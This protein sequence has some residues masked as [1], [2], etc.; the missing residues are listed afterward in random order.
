MVV[1][2][3]YRYR[4]YPSG[5][6]TRQLARE[7][8]CARVVFND[9]I[10]A[11]EQARKDGLPFAKTSE[12]SR[13][14]ITEAKTTP[15]RAWFSEV[16][17]VAL[18]S[19]LQDADQAYKNFFNSLSGKRKGKRVGKPRAK[20]RTARQAVRYTRSAGFRVTETTHGVGFVRLPKMGK[21]RFVLSRPLPSEP[22]SVTVIKE[23]DDTYYVSFVVEVTEPPSVP[24]AGH[25]VAGIDMG[26]TDFATITTSSGHRTKVANPRYFRLAERKLAT[27]QR[28]LAR[29]K[30]GSKNYGKARIKV[31]RAH[32]KVRERRQDF[33][34]KLTLD[35]V[36]D[37]QTIAVETLSITGL[38]RT[39]LAKSVHDASWGM[40]LRLLKERA[41]QYDRMVIEIGQFEPTSQ[42][43][44]VCGVKDGKK[45]LHVRVWTCKE[46]GTVLDRD[47][48]AAVNII[49]AA[50]LAETL[51]GCGENVRRRLA[52]ATIEETAAHRTYSRAA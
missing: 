7:F 21:V 25:D 18:Q 41:V 22:S 52:G 49:V 30:K 38:A 33:L 24:T 19:S 2:K 16:S 9:F 46:C 23:A 47:Y 44:S 51:N 17:V 5:D 13:R 29:K 12:L 10:T 8:G 15:E 36:R 40:F 31:A 35:I 1:K 48:N 4:A 20:K 11:R 28:G 39:R 3:R 43:C 26:L 37:N 50:G 45:P 32:R 34:S 27:L 14:L 42:V 6:Q